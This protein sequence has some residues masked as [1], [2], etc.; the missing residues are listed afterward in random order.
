MNTV[1]T[2]NGK[3]RN[4]NGI[5]TVTTSIHGVTATSFCL[6]QLPPPPCWRYTMLQQY[7][8]ANLWVLVNCCMSNC[9]RSSNNL[10]K[11]FSDY[12]SITHVIYTFNVAVWDCSQFNS[13]AAPHVSETYRLPRLRVCYTL[14]VLTDKDTDQRR[15]VDYFSGRKLTIPVT[16]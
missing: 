5:R 9:I 6:Q 14:A 1:R 16:W 2:V 7:N 10:G 4:S 3:G 11:E 8:V 15:L 12:G 13:G